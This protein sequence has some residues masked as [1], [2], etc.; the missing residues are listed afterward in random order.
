MDHLNAIHENEGNEPAQAAHDEYLTQHHEMSKTGNGKNKA[1]DTEETT[2]TIKAEHV[3][4]TVDSILKA[5]APA[6]VVDANSILA[7]KKGGEQT[8]QAA[9][10]SEG[11]K[12]GAETKRHF[13]V[14]MKGG[15]IGEHR[16]T[17]H[18]KHGKLSSTHDSEEEAKE[19]AKR[20]NGYLSEGEKKYYGIKYHVKPMEEGSTRATETSAAETILARLGQTGPPARN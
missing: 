18:P 8:V 14:F 12:K 1:S 5:K 17:D 20:M 16:E 7:A 19:K 3:E 2:E 10:T 6:P 4:V 13:G 15:S 11:A 9:G